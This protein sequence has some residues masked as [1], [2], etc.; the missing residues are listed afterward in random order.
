MNTY[1]RYKLKKSENGFL[2]IELN[3]EKADHFFAPDTKAGPKIY[4]VKNDRDI[5][6]VGMTSQSI[7]SRLSYGYKT[8]GN[9]GYHGYKWKDKIDQ[10]DLLIW[11]FTEDTNVESIEAELVYFIRGRT[12]KWPKYQMEI[13]FHHGSSEKE[14]QVARLILSELLD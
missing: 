11:T 5:C 4:V 6:Y 14:I 2:P 13:H 10:A 7:S 3:G 12:G 9:N 8:E 1:N